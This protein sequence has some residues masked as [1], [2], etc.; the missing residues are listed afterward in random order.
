MH[1]LRSAEKIATRVGANEYEAKTFVAI[2]RRIPY[3][4]SYEQI[5]NY[6]NVLSGGDIGL[7]EDSLDFDVAALSQKNWKSAENWA[8]FFQQ[9]KVLSALCPKLVVTGK[10]T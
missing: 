9:Y 4:E 2:A 6:F 3:L 5:S 10:S 1:W 7:I 8:A